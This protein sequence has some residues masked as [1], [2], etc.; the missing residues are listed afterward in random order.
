MCTRIS[1]KW[2]PCSWMYKTETNAS[3][4]WWIGTEYSIRSNKLGFLSFISYLYKYFELLIRWNYP[5]KI[6]LWLFQNSAY[7]FTLTLG[8][9][10]STKLHEML[11]KESISLIYMLQACI[12]CKNTV[13]IKAESWHLLEL[14]KCMHCVHIHW[15]QVHTYVDCKWS[16]HWGELQTN[17]NYNGRN[18]QDI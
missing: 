2:A 4:P 8:N 14:L 12:K 18:D 7:H 15:K 10:R 9:I 1:K 3:P 16:L 13:Y 11:Y 17:C 5:Y 6:I